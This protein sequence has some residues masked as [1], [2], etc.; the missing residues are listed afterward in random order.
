MRVFIVLLSTEAKVKSTKPIIEFTC[1]WRVCKSLFRIRKRKEHQFWLHIYD[2][3]IKIT[4]IILCWNG[5]H[6]EE[7]GIP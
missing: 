5:F 3:E 2:V 1:S 4:I 6:M 7:Y